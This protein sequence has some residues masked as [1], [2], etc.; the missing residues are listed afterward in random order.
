MQPVLA[1]LVAILTGYASAIVIVIQA[2]QM[3][4]LPDA[5]LFSWIWAISLG[6]GITSISLSLWFRVPI[7]VAWSTPGAALL[8][9]S[10]GSVSYPE[11]IGAYIVCGVAIVALGLSGLFD[12]VMRL[13][14]GGIASAMLAGILFRF[15][16]RY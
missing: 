8:V 12:R 13:V 11:A 7:S 15:G 3:A 1:G 14:P 6:C 16:S 4:H 2:A 10:L 5:L 9:V